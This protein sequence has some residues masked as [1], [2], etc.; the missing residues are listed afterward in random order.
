MSQVRLFGD[1]HFGHEFMAK[2]RGFKSVEEHDEYIIKIWNSIVHK[3]DLTII[4]GDLTGG[5]AKYYPLLNKLLG[6]KM[7]ILGNHDNPKKI[8]ELLN[9][10][11]TVAGAYKYK[12]YIITHVPIHPQEFDYKNQRWIANIH[13]H[14]HENIIK[15]PRYFCV[16]AE[17]LDY[18]PILFKEVTILIESNKL[19]L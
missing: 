7:A 3:R 2:L 4:P 6:R 8:R 10:V 11:D 13:A 14:T 17:V 9:Y 1:L 16:S 12:G 18:K 19:K 5:S 15:D